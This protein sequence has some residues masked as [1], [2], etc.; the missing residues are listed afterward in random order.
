MRSARVFRIQSSAQ[1]EN[2][3]VNNDNPDLEA[4]KNESNSITILKEEFTNLLFSVYN[5]HR[6]EDRRLFEVFLY[7]M[8][9]KHI[10]RSDM[11]TFL[12]PSESCCFLVE[13]GQGLFLILY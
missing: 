13:F 4:P 12:A 5:L 11:S 6:A 2:P 3:E 7:H 9:L 1:V 8:M 10:E